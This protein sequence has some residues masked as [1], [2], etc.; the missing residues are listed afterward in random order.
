M[1]R[2]NIGKQECADDP[3][4]REIENIL[5]VLVDKSHIF[6]TALM[7]EDQLYKGTTLDAE[8]LN[9]DI[10]CFSSQNSYL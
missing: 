10:Y 9:K 2:K 1:M 5:T 4:C 6:K 7:P 3:G 8:I